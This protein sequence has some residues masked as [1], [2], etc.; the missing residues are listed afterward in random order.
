MTRTSRSLNLSI[1]QPEDGKSGSVW[2]FSG[3]FRAARGAEPFSSDASRTVHRDLDPN[4]PAT[5]Q[6]IKDV[7]DAVDALRSRTSSDD[8]HAA[9]RSSYEF[10]PFSAELV[11]WYNTEVSIDGETLTWNER[12]DDPELL[13]LQAAIRHFDDVVG[14]LPEP[15]RQ[16]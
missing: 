7:L 4:D 5:A 3:T 1:N 15:P 12:R 13:A 10:G 8:G 2:A 6:A 9:E 16:S 14:D 11:A